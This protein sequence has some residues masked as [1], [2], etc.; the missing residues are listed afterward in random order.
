MVAE[1]A[2]S[3]MIWIKLFIPEFKL[4]NIEFQQSETSKFWETS[5]FWGPWLLIQNCEIKNSGIQKIN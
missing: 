3:N 4:W 1:N 5:E 2:K